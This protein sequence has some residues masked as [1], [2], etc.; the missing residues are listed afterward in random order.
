MLPT[1]CPIPSQTKLKITNFS[2]SRCKSNVWMST[3]CFTNI[4]N[5]KSKKIS[6]S[7]P[8]QPCLLKFKA[9][10]NKN[11]KWRQVK[12]R[13]DKRK[14]N[15][16]QTFKKIKIVVFG[17]ILKNQHIHFLVHGHSSWSTFSLHLVRGPKSL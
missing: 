10:T 14:Q 8:L 13:E 3:T 9:K 1:L 7:P 4:Y 2:H 16:G 12:P 6:S 17:H 11:K 5:L 15:N